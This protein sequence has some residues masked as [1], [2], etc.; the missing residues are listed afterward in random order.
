MNPLSTVRRRLRNQRL[1][2]EP[3]GEVADAVRWLGAMQAQEFAEATWSLAERTRWSTHR[4]VEAAFTRGDIVRIHVLRP[5]WHFVA[6][7]DL[8][9]LLRLTRPRIH[10]LNRYWYRKLELSPADLVAITSARLVPIA[11]M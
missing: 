8:R 10:A 1:T 6:R 4:E 9:W 3:F 2:G 5:T 7:E 11:T